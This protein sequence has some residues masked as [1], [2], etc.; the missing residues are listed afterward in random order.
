MSAISPRGRG[1]LGRWCWRASRRWSCG[2]L[3]AQLLVAPG[4]DA[5]V[6]AVV[7]VLADRPGA[8]ADFDREAGGAGHVEAEHAVAGDAKGRMRPWPDGSGANAGTIGSPMTATSSRSTFSTCWTG[9]SP[10]VAGC[11]SR[12]ARMSS[13]NMFRHAWPHAALRASS[14]GPALRGHSVEPF[15]GSAKLP[16]SGAAVARRPHHCSPP[17]GAAVTESSRTGSWVVRSGIARSTAQNKTSSAV[18]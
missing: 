2:W 7:A 1:R 6:A 15:A 10:G 16:H 18:P 9:R 13:S 17:V 4:A 3:R 14:S 5:V 8:V 12:S 11:P